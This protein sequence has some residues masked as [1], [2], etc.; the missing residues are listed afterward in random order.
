MAVRKREWTAPNGTAKQ[1]WVADYRDQAGK[2]HQ[3]QFERKKDAEAYLE[4]AKSEIR[5][6]T[7]TADAESVTVSRAADMWLDYVRSLRDDDD[8]PREASTIAAY[9]QHI[10]LHIVPKCGATKLSQL[11]APMVRSILDDWQLHLSR[12]M[13]V[14]VLR[15]LKAIITYAQERGLVA[16]NVALAVKVAKQPRRKA[17]IEPL[18][19]ATLRAVLKACEGQ[20]SGKA[21]TLTVVAIYSGLR[22]SELRGLS[23]P[24]VDL[25]KG[26]ITVEQRADA[27]G[28]IGPPKSESGRR[29]IPLPNGAVKKLKEWKLACPTSDL[30]LVFPSQSGK[31]LS[32]RVMMLNLVEPILST[33]GV[34]KLGMHAFR[35]AA[36]SLWIDQK[37]S[38][39]RVQYLMGHSSIQVTFDT[40]GHLFEQADQDRQDADAIEQALLGAGRPS[41]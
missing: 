9:D 33:A 19:K 41:A 35:H 21:S 31:P 24:S 39:K 23:W 26:S 20:G 15:T 34:E 11:T 38:P 37:L 17:K 36:A 1:A 7:H 29:T 27:K 2:R 12:P 6:G 32:H 25:K 3:P 18:P 22:A 10:R 13:T 40:Y 30:N 16:Q 28:D 5:L 4:K 8:R 14:R